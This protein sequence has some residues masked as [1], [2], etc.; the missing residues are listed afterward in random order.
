M[1]TAPP[2]SSTRSPRSAEKRTSTRPSGRTPT[3]RAAATAASVLRRLCAEENGS[4]ST[5]VAARANLVN[6]RV[7]RARAARAARARRRRRTRMSRPRAP[8]AASAPAA[9][10][11]PGRRPSRRRA[12]RRA[13]RALAGATPSS[14]PTCSTCTGPIVVI[15]PT[16]GSAIAVSSAICPKP[17]HPISS[18]S[19][20]VPVGRAEDRQ[21]QPDLGVVVRRVGDHAP[22][23]GDQRRDQVLRRG[24]ARPSP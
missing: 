19:T 17:A 13:A 3:A 4:S 2:G 9:P 20:S 11:R 22:V 7:R 8:A 16:S 12:A 5:M 14:E 1:T 23:R 21:R 10:R 6:P 24:L 18:T 15:T